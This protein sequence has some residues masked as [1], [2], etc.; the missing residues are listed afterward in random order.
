MQLPGYYYVDTKLDIMSHNE[1][2]IVDQEYE[3]NQRTLPSVQF[4]LP[5]RGSDEKP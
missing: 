4:L 3:K 2:Y 5:S 1:D